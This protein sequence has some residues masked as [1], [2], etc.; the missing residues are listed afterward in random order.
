MT[1]SD[2]AK[3]NIGQLVALV[4]EAVVNPVKEEVGRALEEGVSGVLG[5]PIAQ[6]DP[7]ARQ[8][9]LADEA[10]RKQHAEKVI[11][12]YQ[13]IDQEQA[14]IR[15]QKLQEQQSKQQEESQKK[16]VQQFE[17]SKRNQP[18]PQAV[19]EAQRKTEVKKGI[20]G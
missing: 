13:K 11:A 9:R 10:N 16:Q 6:Q 20:G 2:G 8:K 5:T 19:A 7:N 12:W 1:M 18:P 15:Q 14:K 17:L 3:A 4:G